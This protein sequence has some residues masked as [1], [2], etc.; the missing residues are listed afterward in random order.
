MQS[1]EVLNGSGLRALHPILLAIVWMLNFGSGCALRRSFDEYEAI[2]ADDLLQRVGL[3]HSRIEDFYG[4]M[5][6]SLNHRGIKGRASAVILFKRPGL[7]KIEVNAP[8]GVNVLTVLLKGDWLEVYLPRD[9]LVL[10]GTRDSEAVH[11]FIGIDHFGDLLLSLTG[12]WFDNPGYI[13][14]FQLRGDKYVL[15]CKDNSELR[16]FWFDAKKLLVLE[17]EVF[18]YRGNLVRKKV[19]RKYRKVDGINLPGSIQIN[20]GN[21]RVKVEYITQRV[22]Q[23]L[24]DDAFR[25]NLPEGVERIRL[26]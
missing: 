1:T 24:S 7:I 11:R 18:D 16:R 4:T 10:E 12:F 19:F 25:L 6:L 26:N 13:N 14:D 5:S 17:E 22:N 23:G 8:L 15:L 9:N 21:E 3:Y 20:T 2:G